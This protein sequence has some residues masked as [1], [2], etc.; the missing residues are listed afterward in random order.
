M[1]W[2]WQIGVGQ[3]QVLQVTKDFGKRD[4]FGGRCRA[5]WLGEAFGVGLS[6]LI[7]N[8]VMGRVLVSKCGLQIRFQFG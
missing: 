2:L 8:I 3:L 5:F 7:L 6:L 1:P 4:G